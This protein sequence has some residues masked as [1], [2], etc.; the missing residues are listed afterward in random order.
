ME[1]YRSILS[2]V[3]PNPTHKKKTA[4]NAKQT[5]IWG[6]TPPTSTPQKVFNAGNVENTNIRKHY[7]GF[8]VGVSLRNFVLPG[9]MTE[10]KFQGLWEQ[11]SPLM[12]HRCREHGR[13]GHSSHLGKHKSIYCVDFT[14]FTHISYIYNPPFQLHIFNHMLQSYISP[15][16]QNYKAIENRRKP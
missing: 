1:V 2:L 16:K 4:P 9:R 3:S 10:N 12:D 7:L 5:H 6:S 15:P 11:G 8:S 13:L 14:D